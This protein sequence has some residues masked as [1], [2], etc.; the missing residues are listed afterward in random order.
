M[1]RLLACMSLL[2]C[3]IY[4]NGNAAPMAP[5]SYTIAG[6][7]QALIL[8]HAFPTDKRLWQAQV[9]GLKPYFKVIVLDLP[10]FGSAAPTKGEAVT[11]TQYADMVKALMDE[12]HISKAI[13]GGESMGGYVSLAFLKKYP[14]AVQGLI[15]SDTQSIADTAEAK[16]KREM[17]A[18]QV[19]QEGTAEV[20]RGFMPKALSPAAPE[21]V[22]V[23][24][25]AIVDAQSATGVASALR[26]MAAREDT[27]QLLAKTNLP[28]LILTGDADTLISPKQS[29][30]M[31]VLAKNSELVMIKNAGHLSSLEQ[32]MQW[33]QAVIAKFKQS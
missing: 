4:A 7:G 17:S 10:G 32:P 13:I 30:A 8:I 28:I 23:Y 12:L 6:S 11:M 29:E 19:L 16:A 21:T 5:T 2:F 25:Q 18:Q 33:N 31:H 27:S 14:E 1:K 9:D 26:G 22:R 20:I 24:L 3:V 15:L